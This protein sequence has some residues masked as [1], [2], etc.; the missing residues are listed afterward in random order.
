M[1]IA[2]TAVD[3]TAV[4]SPR[5]GAHMLMSLAPT[6][7]TSRLDWIIVLAI[8]CAVFAMCVI[9]VVRGNRVGS[10]TV[11]TRTQKLRIKRARGSLWVL[12]AFICITIAR[13]I[14]AH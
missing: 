5:P 10:H 14:V 8:C 1:L 2:D 11:Q 13:I 12:G 9:I 7:D 3:V 4:G 6:S